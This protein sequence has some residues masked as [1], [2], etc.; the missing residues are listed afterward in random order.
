MR[1][2]SC[3]VL[4]CVIPSVRRA[5]A[6]VVHAQSCGL[7]DVRI[8]LATA[9]PGDTIKV[10]PGEATW[11]EGVDITGP[12][13]LKGAG[14]DSTVVINGIVTGGNGDYCIRIRPESPGDD[15]VIDVSGFTFDANLDGGCISIGNTSDSHAIHNVRIHHNKIMNTRD[16]GD[17]YM[18]VRSKGNCFGLIDRNIFEN[19]HYDLKLYGNDR[20]SWDTW[21][22]PANLGTREYLYIED[23]L[24]LPSHYFILT[25]GEGARWVYRRNTV[26]LSSRG[27]GTFDAHGNT[28]NDGVVAHELYE[29]TFVDAADR[30][31]GFRF[32]DLR[33]GTGIVFGNE[34]SGEESFAGITIREEDCWSGSTY[35]HCEYPGIDPVADTYV[36]DNTY[37]DE[38]VRIRVTGNDSVDM[39][40]EDR[41]FWDDYGQDDANFTTGLSASRPGSCSDNDCFWESDT[42]M[43][44]RCKGN[45][46][47]VL[48]YTP[49]TYPHPLAGGTGVS[50]LHPGKRVAN[51]KIE[52]GYASGSRIQP[53]FFTNRKVE[54]ALADAAVF[55]LRGRAV[56]TRRIS[57]FRKRRRRGSGIVVIRK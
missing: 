40:A 10:P 23:N 36:W 12:C 18:A 33:G 48:V 42:R 2:I 25:S 43:L 5:C 49:F 21:P 15:P 50:V 55:D 16:D 57:D 4:L 29:N 11:T 8:A 13:I 32:H 22:G 6:D 52:R 39:I 7:D 51:G 28:R 27:F 35:R 17:S 46:N 54:R 34:I 20:N 19:N 38:A 9:Q 1:M 53:V 14:I 45:D 30:G 56:C 26:D 44:Y 47:W 24:S 3:A 37:N 31:D 41:D